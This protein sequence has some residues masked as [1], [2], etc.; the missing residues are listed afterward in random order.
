MTAVMFLV[1]CGVRDSARA[2]EST[3]DSVAAADS[4]PT[5]RSTTTRSPSTT[6][7][8][9]TT[10]SAPS[11]STTTTTTTTVDPR[12]AVGARY[13]QIAGDANA[14]DEAVADKYF[15]AGDT[16][17]WSKVPAFCAETAPIDEGFAT[18]LQGNS[19]PLD[20]QDEIN[21]QVAA[22]VAVAA[23][24]RNCAAAAGTSVAQSPYTA[25]INTANTRAITAATATR[26][27]LGLPPNR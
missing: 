10:T 19:W 2:P 9:A 20:V 18:A 27:A 24:E 16:L 14:Q 11:D 3:V 5:T 12:Q 23:L 26:L 17:P 22:H 13:Q 4:S 1:G 7:L 8:S 15:G 6:R 21:E 25:K